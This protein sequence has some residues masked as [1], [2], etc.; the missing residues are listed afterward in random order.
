MEP[1]LMN[2][3]LRK[4]DSSEVESCA[5]LLRAGSVGFWR[6]G[7]TRNWRGLSIA[8]RQQ[9]LLAPLAPILFYQNTPQNHIP[10]VRGSPTAIHTFFF[11]FNGNLG[12]WQMRE[13]VFRWRSREWWK[14]LTCTEFLVAQLSH[15]F[16]FFFFF[17]EI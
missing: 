8:Y 1:S 15:Q 11:F 3:G 4:L 5:H 14:F 12:R 2:Y 16:F 17:P 9:P 13:L 7:R 10:P 6:L